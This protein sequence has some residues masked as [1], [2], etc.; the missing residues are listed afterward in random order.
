MSALCSL[1]LNDT[2]MSQALNRRAGALE[3]LGR[4]EEALRGGQAVTDMDD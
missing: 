1:K 2:P 4:N 3:A